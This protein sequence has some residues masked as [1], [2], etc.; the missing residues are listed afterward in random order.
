MVRGFIGASLVVILSVTAFGQSE[1]PGT[2]EFADVHVSP[3]STSTFMRSVVHAG[4]YEIRNASILDLIRTAYNLNADKVFGG[5]AWLDYDRFDVIG[6]IPSNPPSQDTLKLMLQALLAERFKLAVHKDTKPVAGLVLSMGKAKPKMKEAEGSGDTGCKP[7]PQPPRPPTP[8]V[9]NIPMTLFACRNITMEAFA[10]ALRGISTGYVSNTVLDLTGLKGA[11]DFDIKFT[12]RPLLPLAGSDGIT[13]SDAIDKQLGL[14]LEEQKIPTP[15][16]VVDQVNEQPTMNPADLDTKFPPAPPAEFEVADIKPSAPL[17]AVNIGAVG[18]TGFFPG[19]RVNLPRFPLSIAMMWGWNLVSNDDIVNPPKWL[20]STSFD[21]IAKAPPEAAPV[22]GNAPLQ[23]LG[24]MLKALLIDR[25]KLKAHFE[26]RPV[27]A[28]T[29]VAAKPKLKKADPSGRTGCRTDNTGIVIFNGPNGIPTR[30]FTCQNVTMAQFADQ[31]QIIGGN[32]VHYPVLDGTGI[33]GAWDFTLS[34]SPI[35]EAQL[36]G[37]R[38]ATP[39]GPA[40]NGN[41]ASDPVG[42]TSLF[43]AV[44]KQL[45]LKLEVQKRSYPGLVIDHIEEK[46]TDN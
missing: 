28:Y 42:G 27:N 23:D 41:A 38:G 34:F 20:S 45:G 25:F 24:P 11:W 46:P 12:Q 5:P 21:I 15:V 1:P 4:R 14:K 16:I 35:S 2:F 32:Y 17:S 6:K 7:Q 40:P 9:P 44:E 8:G 29:L 10:A 33:E 31:L 26:E 39:F 3:R 36:N 37:L 30:E 43:E 13:L 18:Q 19:G 22:S